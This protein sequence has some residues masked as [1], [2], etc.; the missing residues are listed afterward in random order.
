MKTLNKHINLNLF[1]SLCKEYNLVTSTPT[2]GW[3]HAYPPSKYLQQGS[4][5]LEYN[6]SNDA[7][8]MPANIQRDMSSI[9]MYSTIQFS[10]NLFKLM[11][12]KFIRLEKELKNIEIKLRLANAND[13]FN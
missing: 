12:N 4:F 9:L 13:D 1:N 7:L 6:S 5:I 2:E 3:I 11:F 8:Y 10:P